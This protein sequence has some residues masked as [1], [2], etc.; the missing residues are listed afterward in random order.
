MGRVFSNGEAEV[1][2]VK[3]EPTDQATAEGVPTTHK[4]PTVT[5]DEEGHEGELHPFWRLLE[6]AGYRPW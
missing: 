5:S 6:V 4:W 1:G 2:I 3:E